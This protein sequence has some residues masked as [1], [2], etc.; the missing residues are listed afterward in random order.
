MLHSKRQFISQSLILASGLCLPQRAAA[1][2][3][4]R[5]PIMDL[6][7]FYPIEKPVESDNDL[8]RLAGH[9]DRAKGQVLELTGRVLTREGNPVPNARIE[10][11]QANAAG[12][13]SHVGDKHDAPLDTNFQGYG[14]QMT[15]GDG[16]YRFLTIKPGP[17]P[18]RDFQ[19]SP[20]IH[21]DVAGKMDRLITQ[22]YFPGDPLLEQDRVLAGNLLSNS[23]SGGFPAS[24]FGKLTPS[25]ATAEAGATLCVFDIVLR[26]G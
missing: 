12:R 23:I 5:T 17:Y 8:T 6:G 9:S 10:L 26:N 4:E 14:V 19:R 1:V 24:L 22:M 13:Y 16:R 25:V 2:D 11:W 15:D 7:P 18:A 21:F 3:L 20:H